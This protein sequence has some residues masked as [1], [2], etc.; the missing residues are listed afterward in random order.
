[1]NNI[2][3]LSRKDTD[4]KKKKKKLKHEVVKKNLLSMMII[5]S[6]HFFLKQLFN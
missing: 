3:N 6:Q 1:M 5:H 2:D 4:L